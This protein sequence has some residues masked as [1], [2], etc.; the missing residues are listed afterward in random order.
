VSNTL[1]QT[2]LQSLKQRGSWRSAHFSFATYSFCSPLR[3]TGSRSAKQLRWSLVSW[4][5]PVTK[6]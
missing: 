6:G 5:V 3:P 1:L 2:F 4:P